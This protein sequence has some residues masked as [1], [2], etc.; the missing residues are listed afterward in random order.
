MRALARL[1]DV[2]ELQQPAGATFLDALKNAHFAPFRDAE[3]LGDK[4]LAPDRPPACWPGLFG[5][6][7]RSDGALCGHRRA[8]GAQADEREH[9]EDKDAACK[10]EQSRQGQVNPT[11]NMS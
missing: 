9:P 5:L 7:V 2:G 1:F 10:L 4:M 3:W 8:I 6:G 11:P